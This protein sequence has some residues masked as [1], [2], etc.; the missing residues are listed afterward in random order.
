[1]AKKSGPNKENLEATRRIFIDIARKEFSSEGFYKAST[2]RIV[3]KADMARGSLY[4]HFDDKKALFHAVYE[5]VLH[6]M[7]HAM[8]KAIS[9]TDEPWT[10]LITGCLAAV[11]LFTQRETRR[12][13]IDVQTA[14]SYVERMDVLKRTVFLELDE[15]LQNAINRGY[16]K[17]LKP[18]ALRVMIFGMLS[19]GGRSFELA[20]DVAKAREELGQNFTIFMD[21]VRV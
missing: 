6:E 9:K 11:D 7:A 1:M 4:Y 19:E 20:D 15:L 12:I 8:K 2:A 10:A 21:S 16:L 14:L 3:E 18:D 13:I 17:R 5:E